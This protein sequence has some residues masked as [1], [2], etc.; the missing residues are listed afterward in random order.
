MVCEDSSF[1][2]LLHYGPVGTFRGHGLV[3]S[4][5]I[6]PLIDS[7]CRVGFLFLRHGLQLLR[8]AAIGKIF[9]G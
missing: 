9:S 1:S 6:V 5:Y 8:L 2:F 4:V 3:G 7:L